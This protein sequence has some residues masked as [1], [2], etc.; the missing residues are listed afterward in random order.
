MTGVRALLVLLLALVPALPSCRCSD[1]EVVAHLVELSGTIQRDWSDRL[2]QWQPAALGAEFAIGDAVRSGAESTAV[3]TLQGNAKLSLTPK[4]IVRFLQDASPGTLGMDVS[5]GSASVETTDQQLRITS[6]IGAVLVEPG[7]QMRVSKSKRGLRF[8]VLVGKARIEGGDKAAGV[9][10]AGQGI[11]VAIGGAVLERFALDQ[12]RQAED[13]GQDAGA[14]EDEADEKADIIAH[15]VGNEASMR[16]P[17]GNWQKLAQGS[18]KL[19]P[20]T[21]VRVKG[22]STVTIQ[23]GK[24]QA[25]LREGEFVVGLPGG[26]LVQAVRGPVRLSSG[27]KTSISV[28]GGVIVAKGSDTSAD[29]LVAGKRGTSVRVHVGQVEVRGKA[30]NLLDAGESGVLSRSGEL[31]IAGRGP[32]HADLVVSGGD[33]FTVHDPRPPTVVGFRLSGSC[34]KGAVV[35]VGGQQWAARGKQANVPFSPGRRGYKVSCLG[36]DGPQAEVVA[37][38]TVIVLRDA[39][40]QA[41]ARSA[42]TTHVNTDGRRYTVLYQ[43]RLPTI[44][45]GWANAPEAPSYALQV[46]SRSIRT[47]GPNY[48]FASGTLQEGTHSVRFEAATVPPRRSR[49]TTIAIRFD[50]ATPTASLDPV[51]DTQ[52]DDGA[53]ATISG[54]ALPGWQVTVGGQELKLDGQSRF[55][56]S[57]KI[58]EG[59]RS[60]PVKFEHP[61]RGVHY[62]LRR[63]SK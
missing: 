7:T 43:N 17:G 8:E 44:T 45:V 35:V 21:G 10:A 14:A 54:K 56:G 51:P 62:Y 39:G 1:V 11:E 57:A 61:T 38:G 3:L 58:P 26:Y 28:P 27:G 46:D 33:S 2:E 47:T 4:T 22:D 25:T 5:V 19:D 41:L 49:R 53:T 20:G 50:N 36:P 52:F 23:R 37:Q 34:E 30:T 15:T 48:A 59:Q 60:L 40:T 18:R 9:L 24:Q 42:P 32:G 29:V 12:D 16:A 63:P 31:S 6:S 55:R 13:A